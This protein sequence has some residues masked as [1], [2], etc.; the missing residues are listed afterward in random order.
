MYDNDLDESASDEYVLLTKKFNRPEYDLSRFYNE[1]I[2]TIAEGYLKK[3]DKKYK[4][5]LTLVHKSGLLCF[6]ILLYND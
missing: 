5:E 1:E 6:E 4:D 3:A 2:L